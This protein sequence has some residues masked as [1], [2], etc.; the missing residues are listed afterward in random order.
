MSQRLSKETIQSIQ[1][2]VNILDIVGQFVQL[3]KQGKSLFGRCPFHDE[4]TPSFTVTEEKQLFHCF[5]CGRGG[6]VFNFMQELES[7]SFP[8]SVVRVAELAHIP[9]DVE[10]PSSQQTI[11]QKERKLFAAHEKASEFYSHVLFNTK[12]GQEA[13]HYLT[14]RGYTI[15]TLKEFGFG[16]SLKDRTQLTQLLQD[17]ELTEQEMEATGLFVESQTGFFDR[18]NQRIMIPLR[19][20]HGQIVGFS[21]RVLPGYSD[22]FASQA[23][24]LNSPETPLFAKRNFLF[25]FDLAKKNIRKENKVIL[26]EGYM[27]VISA[28]QAGVQLG[29]ASMGTSLTPEQIQKLRHV[30]DTILIA[31]DG[32]RAGLEATNRAIEIIQSTNAFTIGIIPF[33]NGLDPDE[34]IK[35]RGPQAFID[36]VEHGQETIYQFKKRF[37]SKKYQL[38]VESQKI[39]YIEEMIIELAKLTN[40]VEKNLAMKSLADEFNLDYTTI[41]NQVKQKQVQTSQNFQAPPVTSVETQQ[42]PVVNRPFIK[43]EAIQRHLMYRLMHHNE[44]WT[45]LNRINP[46]FSFPDALYEQLFLNIQAFRNEEEEFDVQEFMLFLN[47]KDF[48]NRNLVSEIEL[49][50]FPPECTE[51]EIQDLV[52]VLSQKNTL[53]EQLAQKK[54]ELNRAA[55][56]NDDEARKKLMVEIMEIQRQLRKR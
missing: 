38:Q 42:V 54:E 8:E 39:Q 44:A 47:D 49:G 52:Y 7:L 35:Q 29:V 10:M 14:D 9:L 25:N 28:W 36:L 4:R 51:Q 12:G 48:M 50:Q 37:L 1:S 45:Y 5:S 20:E 32:D 46:E 13:L 15:D 43:N 41:Q 2:Q 22:E 21:G 33:D 53:K 34:F 56:V 11:P 18:F 24:Y 17:L 16:F 19:N 26:F 23:K 31:Y 55:L 30:T 27:D 3:R 6:N 40:D